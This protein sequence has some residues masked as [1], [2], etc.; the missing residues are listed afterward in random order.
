MSYEV[1][2]RREIGNRRMVNTIVT[3]PGNRIMMRKLLVVLLLMLVT[4]AAVHAQDMMESPSVTVADQVILDG[5]VN[6]ESAYSEGPGFI[7]IHADNGGS[8]GPVAG[9]AALAGG[10]N[11]NVTVP[12]DASMVTPVLFA[13]L[14]TDDGTVGAYEFDGQSGLDSPVAVDGAVVTPPFNVALLSAFDQLVDMNTITIANVTMSGPGWVV[15]H[16]D[17][18]GAPGPVFGQVAVPAG[19]SSNLV[20]NLPMDANLGVLWP[21]LHVDDGTDGEYVFVGAR[22]IDNP[23]ALGGQVATFPISTVPSVRVH[24]QIVIRGDGMMTPMM[25]PIVTVASVLSRGPGFIVIH[26]DNNGAPG[27]VAG[28]APVASGS[29]QNVE[30]V[31]DQMSPTPVLHAMLHT[32]DGVEGTYEFDGA[33]GLDNPV[34]VN[35]AVVMAP[36]NVAPSMNFSAQTEPGVIVIDRVL[37]DAAGWLVIHADNNGSPGPVLGYAPLRDGR[38]VNV[39]VEVDAAA[40]GAQVF[41]ML[42]YDT[43]EMGVYEFGTVEGADPPVSVNGS[44]IV[45]PLATGQ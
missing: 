28:Y 16:A 18:N 26:T 10:W 3:Q 31:L 25:T 44:V 36:F 20:L 32:D 42:H 8:P 38:N 11:R 19:Q 24:D 41:P 29:N 43:N 17:N 40:A 5:T 33:S 4:V 6:I 27:P 1:T 37:I 12:V 23:V 2:A 34:T 39:R 13:M 22:G 21:M 14:H 9:Y 45:L 7:V 30:V 15:V 35:D